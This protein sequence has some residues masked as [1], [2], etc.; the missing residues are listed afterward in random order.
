[1]QNFQLFYQIDKVLKQRTA[2]DCTTSSQ[3]RS[4]PIV[5]RLCFII[6]MDGLAKGKEPF[7]IVTL[8]SVS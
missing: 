7:L 6:Y 8:V 4:K 2:A 5:V 3:H 1:M